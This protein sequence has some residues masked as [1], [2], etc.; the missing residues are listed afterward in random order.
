M[1][2]CRSECLYFHW[3][4]MHPPCVTSLLCV[5]VHPPAGCDIIP[6]TI[7]LLDSGIRPNICWIVACGI[8]PQMVPHCVCVNRY[9]PRCGEGGRDVAVLSCDRKKLKHK[10]KKN[11]LDKINVLTNVII[12]IVLQWDFISMCSQLL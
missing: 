6:P 12:F 2:C 9:A 3:S 1:L 5:L 7:H 8:R 4:V 11:Y 10:G